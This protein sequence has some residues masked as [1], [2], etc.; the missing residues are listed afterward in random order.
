M[1]QKPGREGGDFHF[2]LTGAVCY[3]SCVDRA[4]RGEE[5]LDLSIMAGGEHLVSTHGS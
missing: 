3:S 5:V 1:Q 2:L 4:G